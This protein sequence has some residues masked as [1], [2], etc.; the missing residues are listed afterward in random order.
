MSSISSPPQRTLARAAEA[1]GVGVHSGNPALLRLL[2]APE[3]HGLIFVRADLDGAPEIAAHPSNIKTESLVRMTVL[4]NKTWKGADTKR[5][6]ASVGMI[7]HLLSACAGLGL[8]NLRAELDGPECPIFDGSAECYVRMM[9]E[10]GIASQSRPMK[11]WRLRRPVTL[12]RENAELIALP[13]QSTRYSFFAEFRHAGLRDEQAT[14]EMFADD[15]AGEIAPARTFCFWKDIE[16]LLK[17]G[18]IKGGTTDNAIVIKDGKPV[19]VGNDKIPVVD[20]SF[21]FRL[22][23]ELA[24][25]KLL[26]LIGDLA[27]LGGPVLALISAR[28]SG[29]ALH[30][31]FAQMLSDE[32]E[33]E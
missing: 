24:R 17:A 6:G 8:T 15:Y 18:L 20:E 19:R 4:E 14:F 7:E 28:A 31:E 23:N 2:P 11:R 25:H 13:A 29:H 22:P 12:L 26:D 30:Q 10:A 3:N 27:V 21:Q 16:M 9:N 5:F 32:I 33:P 1:Q